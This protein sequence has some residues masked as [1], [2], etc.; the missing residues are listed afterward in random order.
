MKMMG[1]KEKGE[2]EEEG[3]LTDSWSEQIDLEMM[4]ASCVWRNL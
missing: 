2:E 4:G 3:E 1:V